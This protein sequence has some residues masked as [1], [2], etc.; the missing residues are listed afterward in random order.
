MEKHCVSLVMAKQL[1]KAG[2]NQ[3]CF[4]IST[5]HFWLIR[6]RHNVLMI[7][8][9]EELSQWD[10]SAIKQQYAA[11]LATELLEV[12]PEHTYCF[13]FW[14]DNDWCWAVADRETIN[15][16]IGKGHT[17]CGETLPD[18]LAEYWIYLKK[19]KLI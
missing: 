13:K 14:R 9:N 4:A 19:K 6:N 5:T 2:W 11:P 18:A 7:V 15:S 10:G 16:D 8:S 1:K 3:N 12:L 17:E